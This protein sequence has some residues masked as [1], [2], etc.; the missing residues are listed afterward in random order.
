MKIPTNTI[1]NFILMLLL[2]T[3]VGLGI[4]TMIY[5]PTTEIVFI[6]IFSLFIM[7]GLIIAK[8]KNKKSNNKYLT[9]LLPAI[10][11]STLI[12]DLIATTNKITSWTKD[13]GTSIASRNNF[14]NLNHTLLYV[15]LGTIAITTTTSLIVYSY[16][17]YR[18]KNQSKE[19]PTS[20]NRSTEGGPITDKVSTAS[21]RY[22]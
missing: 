5:P 21:Y 13:I 20:K 19:N 12:S 7:T 16:Q 9:I 15:L 22:T 8:M 18:N 4:L 10:L 1:T 6:Q 2:G 14:T 3:K 17:L 11:N